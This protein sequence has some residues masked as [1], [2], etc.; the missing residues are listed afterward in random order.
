GGTEC[1]PVYE[2]ARG[3]HDQRGQRRQHDQGHRKRAL[4]LL[5]HRG[6]PYD[7]RLHQPG[8]FT[9]V[10][11]AQP[12][13]E[14]HGGAISNGGIWSPRKRP[15]NALRGVSRGLSSSFTIWLPSLA[16]IDL[17]LRRG[18]QRRRPQSVQVSIERRWR[19]N[20]EATLGP[21]ACRLLS[22]RISNELSRV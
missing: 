13:G 4:E 5:P 9:P 14:F 22:G 8:K 18:D 11:A 2:A 6:L 17:A 3:E 12:V 20:G 16:A 10:V 21:L 1:A 7:P 15:C 19:R